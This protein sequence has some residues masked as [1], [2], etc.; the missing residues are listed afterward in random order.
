MYK[1]CTVIFFVIFLLFT[2]IYVR[3]I[4]IKAGKGN[5]D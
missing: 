3:G 2:Y 4:S 5:E 1:I